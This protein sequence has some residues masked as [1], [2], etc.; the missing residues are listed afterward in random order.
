MKLS[1]LPFQRYGT[2]R[3]RIRFISSD[4]IKSEAT[5]KPVFKPRAEIVGSRLRNLPSDFK[6]VPGMDLPADVRVGRRTLLSYLVE[7]ITT[8]ASEALREP[9]L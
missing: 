8:V 1:S 4:A 9:E 5:Q 3:G 7:P 2:V 6:L